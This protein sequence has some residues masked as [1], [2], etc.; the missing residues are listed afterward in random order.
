M[1]LFLNVPLS[2]HK[3][4]SIQHNDYDV[5]SD[6]DRLSAFVAK[7]AFTYELNVTLSRVLELAT[8]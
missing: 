7:Q 1:P 6:E 3:T 5:V 8:P 2:S 4:W